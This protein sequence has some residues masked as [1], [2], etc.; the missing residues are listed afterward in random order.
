M[1]IKDFNIHF[2]HFFMSKLY[3]T[4]KLECDR[5]AVYIIYISIYEAL[6]KVY[7]I[8]VILKDMTIKDIY[9]RY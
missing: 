5:E 4:K 9:I 6:Y 1:S 8:Y 3:F 7:D 2:Q